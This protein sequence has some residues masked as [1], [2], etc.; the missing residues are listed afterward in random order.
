[1]GVVPVNIETAKAVRGSHVLSAECKRFVIHNEAYLQPGTW[2]ASG[3]YQLGELI[4][5]GST[6]RVYRAR[7]ARMERQ[8]AIKVFTE[9]FLKSPLAFAMIECEVA[10]GSALNPPNLVQVFDRDEHNG[11]YFLVMELLQGETLLDR[12]V[13]GGPLPPEQ[14][15][16][17]TQDVLRG[18]AAAHEQGVVHRDVKPQNILLVRALNE[19]GQWV[20]RAKLCDFGIAAWVGEPELAWA[21]HNGRSICGTP[22]YMSPEQAQARAVDGRSDLY[23]VGIT[24]FQ[25]LT[26]DVPFHGDSPLGTTAMQVDAPLPSPRCLNP[27]I[28]RAFEAVI[29]RATRKAPSDRYATAQQMRVALLEAEQVALAGACGVAGKRRRRL[30]RQRGQRLQSQPWLRSSTVRMR[31]LPERA[32]R[33]VAAVAMLG[34]GAMALG[35]RASREELEPLVREAETQGAMLWDY[36][37]SAMAHGEADVAKG[38][39]AA[40]AQLRAA[41]ADTERWLHGGALQPT[42]RPDQ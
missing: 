3:R 4:A 12:L 15:V 29:Y 6:C 26:G 9:D 32:T 25:M 16:S 39:A 22:E 23:S 34:M 35:S 10:A 18:L 28:A 36:G 33:A 41:F 40:L 27:S 17:I 8:V 38:T 21:R 31:G 24:L 14:A 37:A 11:Q 19:D 13:R 5:E 7:H 42:M 1:M 30:G 2:L 20:E